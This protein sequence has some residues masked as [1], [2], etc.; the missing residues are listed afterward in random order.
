MDAYAPIGSD[1][2]EIRLATEGDRPALEALALLDAKR[3]PAGSALVA[4]VEGELVAAL[5]L[6]GSDALG[7]PFRPTADLVRLLSVRAAQLARTS[8]RDGRR[9]FGRPRVRVA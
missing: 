3:P 9:V 5:P 6:D 8:K 7:D 4:F 1:H 2:I